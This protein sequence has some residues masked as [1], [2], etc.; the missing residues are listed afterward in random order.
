MVCKPLQ[1]KVRPWT[2]GGLANICAGFCIEVRISPE[3]MLTNGGHSPILINF[4]SRTANCIL[5][6]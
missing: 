3:R 5:R 2:S 4:T 1:P 6:P